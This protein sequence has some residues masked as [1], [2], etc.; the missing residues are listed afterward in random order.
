MTLKAPESIFQDNKKN[1]DVE[2]GSK[3]FKI[4][5]IMEIFQLDVIIAKNFV[6]RYPEDELIDLVEKF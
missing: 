3:E 2:L 6:E 1:K 5:K 4:E